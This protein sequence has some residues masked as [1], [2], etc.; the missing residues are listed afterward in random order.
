MAG[1]GQCCCWLP[2]CTVCEEQLV[3]YISP[4][5]G[6]LNIRW[7]LAAEKSIQ[8][9]PSIKGIMPRLPGD[10]KSK[11]LYLSVCFSWVIVAF[12]VEEPFT[13]GRA[14]CCKP[15][16]GLR[17][18]KYRWE[19]GRLLGLGKYMHSNWLH[20][21]AR[22]ALHKCAEQACLVKCAMHIWLSNHWGK[23]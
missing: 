5:A 16:G 8:M 22:N 19:P 23:K 1:G 13:A 18:M 7:Y 11:E 12:A 4:A 6:R 2:T 9:P 15:Q 20:L 14:K 3:L 21:Q 10:V 17:L